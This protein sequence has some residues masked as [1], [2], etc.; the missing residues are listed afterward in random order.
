MSEL[1]LASETRKERQM[2][3]SEAL[4]CTS[5]KPASFAAVTQPAISVSIRL[6]APGSVSIRT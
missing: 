4:S 2:P 1:L 5:V 3:E 6:R